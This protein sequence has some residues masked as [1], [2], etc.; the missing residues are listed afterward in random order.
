M[1]QFF[2]FLTYWVIMIVML[3]V[4]V[5]F[6]ELNPNPYWWSIYSRIV[7]SVLSLLCVFPA[8]IGSEQVMKEQ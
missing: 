1:K 5:A 2:I 6:I 4:L 3:Y 7:L 8:A